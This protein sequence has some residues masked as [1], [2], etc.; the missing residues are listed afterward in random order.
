MNGLVVAACVV[1][2]L[3]SSVS[4]QTQSSKKPSPCEADIAK[5]R[6]DAGLEGCQLCTQMFLNLYA[7]SLGDGIKPLKI[8]VQGEDIEGSNSYRFA[9]AEV[10]RTQFSEWLV[11]EPNAPLHLWIAGTNQLGPRQAQHLEAEVAIFVTHPVLTGGQTHGVSGRLV[12]AEDGSVVEGY[13]VEERTAK[14]REL[15]YS[16]ISDFLKSWQ[17]ES[18]KK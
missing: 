16:A 13:T 2:A 17:D 11:V 9:A 12:L 18:R 3:C 8:S 10:I 5:A 15:A 7:K 1:C 14:L 4:A 6:S